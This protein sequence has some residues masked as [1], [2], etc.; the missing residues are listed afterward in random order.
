MSARQE[1]MTLLRTFSDNVKR[2]KKLLAQDST[3]LLLLSQL[4]LIR[5]QESTK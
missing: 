1:L 5:V 2:F 4:E 3:S